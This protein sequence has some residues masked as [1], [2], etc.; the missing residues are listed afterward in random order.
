M[1]LITYKEHT[2]PFTP[3]G[4]VASQRLLLTGSHRSL[5]C[6]LFPSTTSVSQDCN[7]PITIIHS[8]KENGLRIFEG[9]PI[10]WGEGS[11]FTPW[12]QICLPV[13]AKKWSKISTH[14]KGFSF[15]TSPCSREQKWS[16][17]GVTSHVLQ[18]SVQNGLSWALHCL[19]CLG[20]ITQFH[21]EHSNCSVVDGPFKAISLMMSFI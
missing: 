12:S 3:Y 2:L 11:D 14:R 17:N 20:F 5:I 7:H 1:L 4:N 10:L 21:R 16:S 13:F 8:Y 19:Y 18:N 9:Y 6:L 15:Y